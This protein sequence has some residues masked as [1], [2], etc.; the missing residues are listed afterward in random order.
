MSRRDEAAKLI[1]ADKANFRIA[2]RGIQVRSLSRPTL[3]YVVTE[4]DCDCD[5]FGL[6][7]TRKCQH[8]LALELFAE[9]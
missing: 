5:Q 4:E 9:G 7:P 2:R 6:D 3:W 1:A 8:M